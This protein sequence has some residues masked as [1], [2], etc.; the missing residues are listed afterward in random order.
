M[1]LC[2][3]TEAAPHADLQRPSLD[4]RHSCVC[5]D[6]FYSAICRS[7]LRFSEPAGKRNCRCGLMTARFSS[8]QGNTRGRRPRL[9]LGSCKFTQLSP[10]SEYAYVGSM[11]CKDVISV[12][13]Q[14]K[15]SGRGVGAFNCTCHERDACRPGSL[16][17]TVVFVK[18]TKDDS[19][20]ARRKVA[21][22]TEKSTPFISE[23]LDF[24]RKGNENASSGGASR[25]NG[26]EGCL[27]PGLQH[28][29]GALD[30]PVRLQ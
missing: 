16:F 5:T 19:K 28:S 10:T 11:T 25:M 20:R 17:D 30:R 29:H 7:S 13:S 26:A 24:W 3:R 27:R 21:Q 6:N 18:P 9:Q 14:H 22:T 1:L 2:R 12:Y 8:N 4:S 23:N 15:N